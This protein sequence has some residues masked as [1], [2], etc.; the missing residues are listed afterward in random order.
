MGMCCGHGQLLVSHCLLACLTPIN[1]IAFHPEDFFQYLLSATSLKNKLSPFLFMLG[2]ISH[3]SLKNRYAGKRTA[4]QVFSFCLLVSIVSDE[5][6][7]VSLI[8]APCM[9]HFSV[10][11][12]RC[13]LSFT[14]LPVICLEVHLLVS[15]LLRILWSYWMCTLMFFIKFGD[16]SVMVIPSNVC[17]VLSLSFNSRSFWNSHHAIGFEVALVHFLSLPWNISV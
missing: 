7:A 16:F 5:Q 6:W 4:W 8:P 9:S 11:V 17:D 14:R 13:S 2:F 10:A 3:L 15:A 12:S 1:W